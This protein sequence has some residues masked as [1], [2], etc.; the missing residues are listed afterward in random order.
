L[1]W[2]QGH[3]HRPMPQEAQGP[4]RGPRHAA[5]W[6]AAAVVPGLLVCAQLFDTAF[7]AGIGDFWRA[8]RG[9]ADG[10]GYDM[11]IILSGYFHFVGDGWRLPLFDALTLG[12]APGTNILLTDSVP[13]LA[14]LARLI[15]LASGTTVNLFGLW[16]ALGF[17]L[18]G[19]G[20]AALTAALGLRSAGGALA[21]AVF[22]VSMSVMLMRWGHLSLGGQFVVPFALAL[23][24]RWLA[25]KP[26]A[27]RGYAARALGLAAVALLINPYLA[28]MVVAI[29]F[30]ALAQLWWIGR[31]SSRTILRHGLALTGSL[32]GLALVCG[33]LTAKIARVDDGYGFYSLNLAAP[34]VP[35]RS[36][37]FPVTAEFVIDGT[38]GQYEG[39]SYLGG[40]VLLLLLLAFAP[41]RL[42]M[43]VWVPRYGAGFGALAAM[44]LFAISHEIY[45]GPWHLAHVAL[46]RAVLDAANVFRSSG[47]F[48]WPA[49]YAVT[50][51]AIS[52]VGLRYGRMGMVALVLAALVQWVDMAPLRTAIATSIAEPGAPALSAGSWRA[53]I[54]RHAAVRVLP[55]AVCAGEL[56]D[57]VWALR[58]KLAAQVLS[59]LEGVSILRPQLARTFVD[60][61]EEAATPPNLRSDDPTLRIYLP[62]L[63]DYAR[64]RA[65]AAGQANCR[66][67]P[68]LVVCATQGATLSEALQPHP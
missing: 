53:L 61:G 67:W 42:P 24:V 30:A 54:A 58:V 14:L 37:L 17:I 33:F 25:A 63:R 15:R 34:F 11:P 18:N 3:D 27:W 32:V 51:G 59:G 12:Q 65:T 10:A 35:Q 43:A 36:G 4:T 60:C 55:S 7:L 50:G 39:F 47:R 21:S 1:A 41:G 49:V 46:P 57:K 22:G 38:G 31:G 9:I 29:L 28:A 26:A 8:P 45:F 68:E 6:W 5:L 56:A 48:V 20:L 64:V 52:A 62:G 66:A 44:L 40:G 23:H 2:L 13:I 19:V 16:T